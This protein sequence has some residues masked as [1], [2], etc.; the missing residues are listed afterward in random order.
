MDNAG[1]TEEIAA[2]KSLL[3][4]SLEAI[5]YA[6]DFA[7]VPRTCFA[8]AEYGVKADEKTINTRPL[9]AAIDAVHEAGGG[10][11]TLPKGVR[12]RDIWA[13][14]RQR[15]IARPGTA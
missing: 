15:L 6:P 12:V 13:T 9:Q 14:R 11:V 2:R 4:Q 7:V 8:A 3:V 5:F 10:V 1:M